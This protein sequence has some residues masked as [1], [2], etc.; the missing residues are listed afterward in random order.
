MRERVSIVPEFEKSDDDGDQQWIGEVAGWAIAFNPDEYIKICAEIS[1]NKREDE[2]LKEHELQE[3]NNQIERKKTVEDYLLLSAEDIVEDFRNLA[4]QIRH[5][6]SAERTATYDLLKIGLN[7]RLVE[8]QEPEELMDTAIAWEFWGA[9]FKCAYYGESNEDL[10][11]HLV[12]HS[13]NPDTSKMRFVESILD[14]RMSKDSDI[15][16][17]EVIQT[18]R[19]WYHDRGRELSGMAVDKL[20]ERKTEK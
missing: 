2:E 1:R 16:A 4:H 19:V 17:A 20:Q 14:D 3:A 13:F 12:N 9:L 18:A 6:S 7:E 5:I 10:A 15:I 11:D 8:E